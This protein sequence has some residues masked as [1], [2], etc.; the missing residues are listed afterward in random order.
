MQLSKSLKVSAV[1]AILLLTAAGYSWYWAQSH[2]AFYA[3]ILEV[4]IRLE[5]GSSVNVPFSVAERGDH[6]IAIQYSPHASDD[7]GK[8]FDEFSGTATL[9]SDGAVLVRAELP[10]A[11]QR[12]SKNSV[13]MVLFSSGMEPSK[14]YAL[15]LQINRVPPNLTSSPAM[16]KV[17]L[18][19][20]YY[21]IF[22]EVKLLGLLLILAGVIPLLRFLVSRL[23]GRRSKSL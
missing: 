21:F 2:G 8:D 19:P 9:T 13:G 20:N 12:S 1:K 5:G 17:E 10:V 15:L 23:F 3:K 18:D 11:H 4:P 7:V 22:W 16:M 14:H 6:D